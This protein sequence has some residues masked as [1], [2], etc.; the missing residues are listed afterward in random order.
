MKP[1]SE[2]N[3]E[4]LIAEQDWVRPLVRRLVRDEASAQDV[5][6]STWLRALRHPPRAEQ[7]SHSWSGWFARVARN[8][9]LRDGEREGARRERELRAARGERLPST[10]EIAEREELRARIV[11]H[12]LA[13][14]E[15]YRATL[16][17]RYY[18]GLEPR[19]IARAQGTNGS[20][21]R[22]RIARGLAL[23]RERMQREQGKEWVS[24]CLAV[25]PL[26][27][28]KLLVAHASWVG[29]IAKGGV[30][31]KKLEIAAAA[32]LAVTAGAVWFAWP[33]KSESNALGRGSKEPSALS[34]EGSGLALPKAGGPGE[35]PLDNGDGGA[36]ARRAGQQ[37]KP[38]D[39]AEVAAAG[40]GVRVYGHVRDARGEPIN[41]SG[42]TFQ[43]QMGGATVSSDAP[44]IDLYSSGDQPQ[45]VQGLKLE[46]SIQQDRKQPLDQ[47]VEERRAT[48]EE[49]DAKLEDET[50]ARELAVDTLGAKLDAN[51]FDQL[52]LDKLFSRMVI[53][54]STRIVFADAEG[55]Q[56]NANS[57]TDS[58]YSAEGLHAG[59]WHTIVTHDG[60]LS[61]RQDF[62]IPAGEHQ[63]QLDIVL[64]DAL[65]VRVKLRTPDGRELNEAIAADP[66]LYFR[67]ALSP[68][69]LR[70]GSAA[71]FLPDGENQDFGCGHYEPRAQLDEKRRGEIGDASGVMTITEAPPLEI[72]LVMCGQLIAKRPLSPGQEEVE[73]V[74]SLEDLRHWF[75]TAV[76]HVVD[77]QT[78][79]PI[80]GASV[81][82]DG[83]RTLTESSDALPAEVA[84]DR[85]AF[86][87]RLD[88][89][90]RALDEKQAAGQQG[91]TTDAQGIV[92]IP[93]VL[94]GKHK[95][96]A[97]AHGYAA[98]SGRVE[99]E[100][101]GTCELKP[102]ELTGHARISGRIFDAQ[103]KPAQASFQL[104]PLDRFEETHESLAATVWA[105]TELGAF[106]VP[107][108]RRERY[109][110]R[111]A[112]GEGV[113]PPV[114]ID[115][116]QGDVGDLEL[117]LLAPTQVQVN[118]TREPKEGAELRVSTAAGLPMLER[119]LSGLAPAEFTLAP[120]AYVVE[121]REG[122]HKSGSTRFVVTKDP[123][124]VVLT[125]D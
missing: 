106:E 101:G 107:Q 53:L 97:M 119:D 37:R 24:S 109:V 35:A 8:L 25:L 47:A 80:V 21:V 62:E 33:S 49:L 26:G 6:Q 2:P 59:K 34:S 14:P 74:L 68:V 52:R 31:A 83:V 43:I 90:K 91:P 92:R 115:A 78:H 82:I 16:V 94:A 73:F 56:F 79:A 112:D 9:A 42:G 108:Q 71:R 69:A 81:T 95:L 28:A 87:A 77:A 38:A 10:S 61:R 65:Q 15:P 32:A 116:T 117:H 39:A 85:A 4:S 55:C 113:L 75:A 105:S 98:F 125:L 20:T 11:A 51:A 23:L 76:V 22:N 86:D 89:A 5:L 104:V 58:S 99:I 63:F 110:L 93:W 36:E 41:N 29:W 70:T 7:G 66:E 64:D 103:G 57:D 118:F 30:V 13:L 102:I 72:G 50:T 17:L 124:R 60:K 46:F 67:A 122:A 54:G 111:I 114:V 40:A 19:A 45:Q 120:G 18:E 27:S 88:D 100:A 12:V 96:Y 3:P 84:E 121:V 44:V 48:R 123:L 1:S